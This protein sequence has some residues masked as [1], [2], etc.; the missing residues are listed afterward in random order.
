MR[1]GFGDCALDTELY[2]LQRGDQ[3]LYLRSKVFQV[4][5]YLLQHRN[6][7]IAKQELYEQIWPD[8][9]ISDAALEGVIK[10]ARQAVGDS[11]RTQWCIQTRRG[12][13]YR[14]VA[15]L[16]ELPEEPPIEDEPS[17]T[18]P[19][20]PPIDMPPPDDDVTPIPPIPDASRRQL[21]VLLCAM[22]NATALAEQ[23]DPEDLREIFQAY[24][25]ACTAVIQRFDGYIAPYLNDRLL[26]YFGYP[27][28]HEDDAQ[29]A[30]RTALG[31]LE[32]IE[33]L[34]VR[35]AD[36]KGLRLQV[37]LTMHTGLVVVGM[38]GEH[39]RQEQLALGQ[40]P[41][42]AAQLLRLATPN[43]VVLS[44]HT[45][46][47]AGAAFDYDDL[48]A[49]ALLET[50][51][52]IRAYSVRAERRAASRFEAVTSAGLIPLVGREAELR[53]LLQHWE[54]A[55]SGEGQVVLLAGEP[56]IGKSRLIEAA[57][58]RI[59]G[60]QHVQLSYQCLPYYRHSA[61]YPFIVQIEQTA[62]L[63]RDDT[64]EQK[65]DKL[66]ARLGQSP[67]ELADIAPLLATLLSI[68]TGNRYPP[69]RL[70]SQ[71][72]KMRTI[73]ALV[74]QVIDLSHAQ[75]VLFIFEDVHWSDPTSLEVLDLMMHQAQD[76]RVLVVVTHRPEFN[77][78]WPGRT[79]TTALTLNR[80]SR[81]QSATLVERVTLGKALPDEVL[82][83]IVMKADGI[84]LFVEELT[85]TVVEAGFLEERADQYAL[86]E[87][88]PSLA[89]PA[90][91]R[92]SLMARLD[93]LAPVVK[94]MAQVG[95]AIGREFSYDLLSA[96][97]SR[98]DR[99][100][101]EALSRLVNAELLFCRGQPPEARYRFKHAL[102]QDAAYASLLRRQR[103][104]LHT[105]IATVIEGQFP[106]IAE[107]EPEVLAHH[108]TAAGLGE[109]AI[110]YWKQAGENAIQ[111]SAHVEA[112]S[113][114]TQAL[115]LLKT[116][117]HTPERLQQELMLNIALGVPLTATRG[118][119]SLEVERVYTQAR[120]L[121]DQVGETATRFP[122]LRGLH[123]FYALRAEL[124]TAR[125]LGEQCLTLAQRLEEPALLLEAHQTLGIALFFTGDLAL[126]HAHFERGIGLYHPHQ[127]HD[128][129]FIYGGADPG[130]SCYSYMAW[131]LWLQ[132]YPDQALARWEEAFALAQE[133]S[134]PLSLNFV[135]YFAAFLHHSRREEQIAQQRAEAMIALS[136]EQ[137]FE[138]FLALGKLLRGAALVRQNQQEGAL[139]QMRQGMAA[140]RGMG[141]ELMR[142]WFLAQ[143][144][145]VFGMQGQLEE[146]LTMLDEALDQV[147]KTGERYYA[148]ELHR[149]QGQLLLHQAS[150][151]A[152][153][154]ETCFQQAIAIAQHQGA[155]SWELRAS[156]S[157]ARLWRNQG[158]RDEARQ[159]LSSIYAR[160]TEG[161]DTP[162]LLAAR[163]LLNELAT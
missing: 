1:Y 79:H 137:G 61:F 14:F 130:V 24:Q 25:S 33:V 47:L 139:A 31:I 114:Y 126:A 70:S 112:I 144:A 92:D 90:T 55:K 135:F 49:H 93:R 153:E 89:I 15:P 38:I 69:L 80:L 154:A 26:V 42:L 76:A 12:Q 75:P 129:I 53:L 67:N 108:Y 98:P 94:D 103:H 62:Q 109:K 85:K 156:T 9:F 99:K 10:A 138:F 52:P 124:E 19:P 146:G 5:Y 13:G 110:A 119:A 162:D 125:E 32:A 104:H 117:P 7:V 35:L 84:P 57:R 101:Q 71:Q 149:L 128:H 43:Q 152:A 40:P 159:L 142:P 86:V 122:A 113:H 48:G 72:Q 95:A 21:T 136:T 28:A 143:L 60:E 6:R 106:A 161:F 44:E 59:A 107:M 2:V 37:C 121:C 155:K 157:L 34:N 8:Q 39:G 134:D 74:E 133:L 82:A 132:G 41:N 140:V 91:L 64:P 87:A 151:S 96:V 51:E 131:V 97:I 22:V 147:D 77:A 145:E 56:G 148:S 100:L 58:E 63:M 127:H 54:Q 120:I 158:K 118:W 150:D 17:V 160:F 16:V 11:G 65:L 18:L 29:R 116:L 115:E 20:S 81:A 66:E 27:H 78:P 73:E 68:P 123:T 45:Q 111:R 141:L 102:V 105:R 36:A 4:L 23:L 83:Q 46:R 30:V 50:S 163:A 3:T 88:L